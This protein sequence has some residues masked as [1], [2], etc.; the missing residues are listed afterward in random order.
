MHFSWNKIATP[1]AMPM[2]RNDEN[3]KIATQGYALLAMTKVI[4]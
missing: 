4:L 1:L 3:N 2:V